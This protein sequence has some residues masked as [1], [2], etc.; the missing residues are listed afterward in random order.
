MKLMETFLFFFN[1]ENAREA[2]DLA[3]EWLGVPK[4]LT[5]EDF[6][7]PNVDEQ[8]MLTY[9]SQFPNAKLAPGAPLRKKTNAGK[10]NFFFSCLFFTSLLLLKCQMMHNGVNYFL[11][12]TKIMPLSCTVEASCKN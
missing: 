1:V 4:L 2:M 7:S 8:S 9:L 5:P 3:D 10:V 6:V 12:F 11:S